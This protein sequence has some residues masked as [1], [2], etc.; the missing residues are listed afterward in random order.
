VGLGGYRHNRRR[1]LTGRGWRTAF[2]VVLALVAI[3]GCESTTTKGDASNTEAPTTTSSVATSLPTATTSSTSTTSTSTTTIGPPVELN[4]DL[5]HDVGLIA[6]NATA[7]EVAL[8]QQLIQRCRDLWP[9]GSRSIAMS[10]SRRGQFVASWTVGRTTSGAAIDLTSRFRIASI[11]KLLT[12][13]TVMRLVEQGLIQLDVPFV[14]QYSNDDAPLDSRFARITVRSLLTHSSGLNGLRDAFF[15]G[16]VNDWHEVVEV[17]Y[18]REMLSEPGTD[19]AYS[20][21]NFVLLGA[22]VEQAT[23]VPYEQAVHQFVLDPLGILSAELVDTEEQPERDPNYAVKP[24]RLYMEALGPAG[25]WVM[26]ATDGARLM[27]A[28]DS[29]IA[30]LVVSA[31]TIAAMR[32]FSGIQSDDPDDYQYGLGL[33]LVAPGTYVGH[34]GTIESALS[35]A[36]LL[37]NGYA[38]TVFTTSENTVANGTGL[39]KYFRAEID[40][41]AQLP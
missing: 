14:E 28:F 6:A 7:Q 40:A 31:E 21:A 24:G 3:A 32:S 16:T 38:L 19:F 17:A 11:S 8:V 5:D 29:A 35:F 13:L 12:S 36:L 41:L 26:T 10:V 33:M 37:P 34:T 39:I 27:A 30:P 15:E 2:V 9:G 25:A 4:V 20:N 18:D 22:L 23:G 1:R